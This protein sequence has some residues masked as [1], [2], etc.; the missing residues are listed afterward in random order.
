MSSDQQIRD[1]ADA[2]EEA[3]SVH[4]VEPEQTPEPTPEP[5]VRNRCV[6]CSRPERVI[7]GLGGMCLCDI[8]INHLCHDCSVVLYHTNVAC[9]FC[10][11]NYTREFV[12]MWG[13]PGRFSHLRFNT[14]DEAV[15]AASA[16]VMAAFE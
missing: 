12:N 15:N 5:L 4:W 14:G 3:R 1:A 10:S 13:E 6:E 7:V 11:T 8:G 2:A 16:A 9:P